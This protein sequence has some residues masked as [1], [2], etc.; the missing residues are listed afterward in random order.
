ME[1]NQCIIHNYM[2]I[3]I[4]REIYIYRY[5]VYNHVSL[6]IVIV[7]NVRKIQKKIDIYYYLFLCMCI[8]YMICKISYK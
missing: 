3:Y 4:E 8:F 1:G 2:Y 7:Q 6:Y 5:I